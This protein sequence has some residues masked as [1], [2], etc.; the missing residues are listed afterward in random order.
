MNNKTGKDLKEGLEEILDYR[1]GK[2]KLKNDDIYIPFVDGKLRLDFIAYLTYKLKKEKNGY[3][4]QCD[5]FPVII[6]QGNS[7][8]EIKIN[9]IK[10]TE[11]YFKDKFDLFF[12]LH[13]Y[14]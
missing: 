14:E 5:Q 13:K 9:V 10:A 3:S 6:A 1:K 2:K 11:H 8:K 12:M 7:A 4:V